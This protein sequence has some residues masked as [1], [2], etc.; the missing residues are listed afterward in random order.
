MSSL[1]SEEELHQAVS[2]SGSNMG[3]DN[4]QGEIVTSSVDNTPVEESNGITDRETLSVKDRSESSSLSAERNIE[5]K[6]GRQNQH[7]T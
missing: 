4:S 6:Q 2:V 1:S 3:D 7:F 5:N